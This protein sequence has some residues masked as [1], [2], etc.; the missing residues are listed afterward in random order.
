MDRQARVELST[1]AVPAEEAFA[2]WRELICETFVQLNAAPVTQGAFAGRIEHVPVGRLELSTVVAAGQVVRRTRS[3]IARSGDEYLLASIQ[4]QGRGLVEQDERRAELRA[5]DMAFYDSTRPYTL[6]FDERFRQLV[7]QVPKRDLAVR[8]TRRLTARTLG[9]GGPGQVVPAFFT[10]LADA[11]KAN[12]HTT[13][14]LLPH[15]LGLLSAAASFAA[16]DE[17]APDPVQ[18]LVRERALAFIRRNLGDP[19][20]DVDLVAGACRVSRRTLY[21]VFTPDGGIATQIRRIRLDR[22]RA[23]LLEHPDRPVAAIAALCGYDSESGFHR[24]FRAE[25]GMTPRECRDGT[26]GQ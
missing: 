15:A 12:P 7:V 16:R 22:A 9:R 6:H 5:G 4:L 24:A 19:G 26:R 1:A 3:L 21:R 2:Y 14:P 17:P 25:F 11:A 23:M 18:A 20:L 13:A 8:D 10:S